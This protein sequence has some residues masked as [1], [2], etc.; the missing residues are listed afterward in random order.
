MDN[1]QVKS[2]LAAHALYPS[3]GVAASGVMASFTPELSALLALRR[4]LN[5]NLRAGD[6]VRKRGGLF[7]GS[8]QRSVVTYHGVGLPRLPARNKMRTAPLLARCV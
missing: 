6:L 4:W 1:E 3:T 7:S 2:W 8:F 5:I